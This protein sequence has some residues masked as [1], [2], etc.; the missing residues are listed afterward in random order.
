MGDP[1]EAKGA[2]DFC[3][4]GAVS[5]NVHGRGLAYRPFVGDLDS[6]VVVGPDGIARRCSREE[7]AGLF[8][9]VCGGYGLFGVVQLPAFLGAKLTHDPEELI[10]S[11][12]YR[13]LRSSIE[14][15]AAA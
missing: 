2:D 11:D 5:A 7:N 8:G 9:L 3:I 14:L 4:G 6:L 15:E 10:Q 12:W 13:W 1:S